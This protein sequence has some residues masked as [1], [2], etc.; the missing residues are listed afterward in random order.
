MT[1]C[2][3][4]Q[5]DGKRALYGRRPIRLSPQDGLCGSI[6]RIG[7]QSFERQP[8]AADI[9]AVKMG[10]AVGAGKLCSPDAPIG[11]QSRSWHVDALGVA[12]LIY[13]LDFDRIK[14][15]NRF[16]EWFS[17]T[18]ADSLELPDSGL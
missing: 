2:C 13:A 10:E 12:K 9:K 6:R 8:I 16:W 1:F 17:Q 18:L 5:A 4:L 14:G 11:S 15:S 3:P 7:P